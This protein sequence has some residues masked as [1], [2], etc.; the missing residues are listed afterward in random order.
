MSENNRFTGD[1]VAHLIFHSQLDRLPSL[2]MT[3]G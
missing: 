3:G 2:G 1:A